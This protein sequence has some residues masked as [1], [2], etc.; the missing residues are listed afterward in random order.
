MK[1]ALITGA[2][3]GIGEAL[4]HL[5]ASKGYRLYLTGRN[6]Q[7]LPP[8]GLVADLTERKQRQ[9]IIELIHQKQPDLVINNAGF[10]IYGEA[11]SI[12]VEEQLKI[13]EV[14]AAALLELTL[15]AVRTWSAAGKGGIVMNVSSAAGE[16]PTP[17]MT[18]YGASKAFVTHFSQSL[19]T[20]LKEKKIFVLVCC[21]GMVATDF[22]NRA[23]GKSVTQQGPLMRADYAAEQIWK[24]IEQKQEKRL[25]DW[26]VQLS[27]W[28]ALHLLPL[29]WIKK[30]IWNRIKERV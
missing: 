30:V 9:K 6:A 4:A 16:I 1:S 14:N 2:T 8:D 23:A 24:Q 13:L 26:K 22:A 5:L 3:S 28:I 11:I 27:T 20:E 19:N 15:E 10:G 7:K 29:T 18:V 21:P 17:G 12:P 25:I